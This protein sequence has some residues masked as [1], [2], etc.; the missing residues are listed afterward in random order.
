M[1]ALL[2]TGIEC[3][4]SLYGWLR[5]A[6][7]ATAG[8]SSKSARRVPLGRPDEKVTATVVSITLQ[9]P[10]EWPDT[11][12]AKGDAVEIVAR[13]KEG[14]EMPLCSHGSISMN[15]A[16]TVVVLA[17]RLQLTIFPVITGQTGAHLIFQELRSRPF[18]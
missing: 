12:L 6:I 16:L 8:S 11:T 15:R 9:E 13:L 3:P 7:R 14:S 1:T 4:G 18:S 17:D 10:L 5:S 2:S